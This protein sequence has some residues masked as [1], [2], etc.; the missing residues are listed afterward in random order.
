MP[1][2]PRVQLS[3]SPIVPPWKSSNSSNSVYRR[4]S[5][6]TTAIGQAAVSALTR[7]KIKTP[8]ISLYPW[9]ASGPSCE[10]I[11]QHTH[12]VLSR[13]FELARLEWALGAQE[14]VHA[15]PQDCPGRA[16]SE[17][18]ASY[19]TGPPTQWNRGTNPWKC[20][21]LTGFFCLVMDYYFSDTTRV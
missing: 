18:H 5:P 16:R 1:A 19:S 12:F 17:I 20:K 7:W 11:T 21:C 3:L 4:T 10:C 14:R 6:Q 8:F 15:S 13:S 9:N 2:G